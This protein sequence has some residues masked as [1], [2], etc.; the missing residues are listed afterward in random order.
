MDLARHAIWLVSTK[1]ETIRRF[2][3]GLG[4]C[5]CYN[6]GR[7]SETNARFDQV[8]KIVRRLAKV[9]KLER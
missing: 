2:I 7:E 5:P 8:V 6:L 3:D 1:R 9:R 4:Y